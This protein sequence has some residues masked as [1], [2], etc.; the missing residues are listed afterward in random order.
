M[1][2]V[3]W[4]KNWS[5]FQKKFEN[6]WLR[7]FQSLLFSM[8]K[9]EGRAPAFE[10]MLQR[11]GLPSEIAFQGGNLESKIVYRRVF[12]DFENRKNIFIGCRVIGLSRVFCIFVMFILSMFA[13]CHVMPWGRGAPTEG[14][15]GEGGSPKRFPFRNKQRNRKSENPQK[16]RSDL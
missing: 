1:I 13:I 4:N 3:A 15:G 5:S 11:G 16:P 2:R 8:R 14:P 9:S 6:F 12:A 7:N 10:L